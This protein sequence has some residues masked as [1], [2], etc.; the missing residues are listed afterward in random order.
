MLSQLLVVDFTRGERKFSFEA[1]TRSDETTISYYCDREL[2]LYTCHLFNYDRFRSNKAMQQLVYLYSNDSEAR[3]DKF[4]EQMEDLQ[5]RFA[6]Q[7]K[8]RLT[9]VEFKD[10]VTLCE[11]AQEEPGQELVMSLDWLT[12]PF[13]KPVKQIQEDEA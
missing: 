2:D 12:A 10:S 8:A 6:H 13:E 5:D 1:L 11:Y 3:S 9:A 4:H 7:F